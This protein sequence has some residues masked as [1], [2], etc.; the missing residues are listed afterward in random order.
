MDRG[1][2]QGCG[3]RKVKTKVKTKIYFLWKTE[4][5]SVI[6]HSVC[7][8]ANVRD[9]LLKY[10]KFRLTKQNICSKIKEHKVLDIL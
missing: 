3:E 6:I 7:L 10:L 9:V 1:E 8:Q 2:G 4:E 5:N